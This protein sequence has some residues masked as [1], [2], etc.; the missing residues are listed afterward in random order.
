MEENAPRKGHLTSHGPGASSP[1]LDLKEKTTGARLPVAIT[2][3]SDFLSVQAG[4]ARWP[5]PS[6]SSTML[7]QGKAPRP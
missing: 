2:S 5:S 1:R 3:K 6:G 7:G 4:K